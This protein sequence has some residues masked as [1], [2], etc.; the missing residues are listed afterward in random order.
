MCLALLALNATVSHSQVRRAKQA[1]GRCA[2][3]DEP[4]PLEGW[5]L[6]RNS[7]TR[8]H[9]AGSAAEPAKAHSVLPR[10]NG[11]RTLIRK[12]SLRTIWGIGTR[13]DYTHVT[14][15]QG[16]RGCGAVMS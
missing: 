14:Q 13:N 11:V 1:M 7:E 5:K 10:H 4:K 15:G 2:Y 16:R 3:T 9:T 8:P 6:L 12:L